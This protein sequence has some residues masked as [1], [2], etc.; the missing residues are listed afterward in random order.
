MA[1]NWSIIASG[2]SLC[3]ED[4]RESSVAIVSGKEIQGVGDNTGQ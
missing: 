4:M 3:Q 2:V 1:S